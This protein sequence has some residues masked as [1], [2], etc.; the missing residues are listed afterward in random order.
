MVQK[1]KT[2]TKFGIKQYLVDDIW[3]RQ[4]ETPCQECGSK[5]VVLSCGVIMECLDC[6]H[7]YNVFEGVDLSIHK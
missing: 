5:N 1:F 3:M 7:K 4:A 2:R 6:G